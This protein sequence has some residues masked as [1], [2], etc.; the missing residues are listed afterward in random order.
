MSIVTTSAN[1]PLE[2]PD[3][4][5]PGHCPHCLCHASGQLSVA[6][7]STPVVFGTAGYPACDDQL[8]TPVAG[9]PPFKPPRG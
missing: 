2:S 7:D 1:A 6:A 8:A 5:V 4:Q 9:L 3:H